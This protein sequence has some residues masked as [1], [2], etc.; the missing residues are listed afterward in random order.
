MPLP[1]QAVEFLRRRYAAAIL[2]DDMDTACRVRLQLDAIMNR[3][4][5]GHRAGADAPP[6]R[7][8]AACDAPP[9]PLPAPAT[10]GG[11]GPAARAGLRL[12]VTTPVTG[13]LERRG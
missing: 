4:R 9:D 1:C 7:M 13:L 6:S 10:P 3:V 2:R 11:G 8:T 5:R 12:L